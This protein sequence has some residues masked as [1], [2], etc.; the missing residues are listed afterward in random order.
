MNVL[1]V[2]VDHGRNGGMWT[3]SELYINS[4]EYNN[5]VNL[6]YVGTSTD[7]SILRRI[8]IMIKGFIQVF[9]ALLFKNI[10]LVHVHMAEKGSVYRKGFVIEL[11]KLF[12]KKVV[13]HMHA[14]PFMKWFESN[15]ERRKKIIKNILNSA[16]KVL[17]LGDY[18][19]KQLE[20]VIPEYKL[21]VL[22]NGAKCPDT[23]LYN[24]DGNLILYLGLLKKTK[25][26]YDLLNAMG[27]I[28]DRLNPETVLYLC[29]ID[30]EGDIPNR[31][32]EMGLEDKV[33][34]L[35]WITPE[36]RNEL[37]LRSRMCVLPSYFEALSM[38]VIESMCY[39]VPMVTTNISTMTELLGN[40]IKKI[41]PGDVNSLGNL[42]LL[43]D[44]SR[45]IRV[46]YSEIEYKR[47]R[48][49]FS[50]EK[51]I[52]STLR[53]YNQLVRDISTNK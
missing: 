2:G 4:E 26:T 34:L 23:N 3:V 49:L 51:N 21:E 53:V 6:T 14:G 52:D 19:K 5:S 48:D 15:S 24:P 29:G 50:I 7:G 28:K 38:T 17:V 37:F 40:D 9:H 33:K 39:G 18:W 44:G 30:E 47:A 11:C 42:L 32:S 10:D 36:S 1:M 22:Y 13:I 20:E 41:E 25:G 46:K 31:I 27:Q 35:G 45:E 43:L 8:V 16:N 12:G